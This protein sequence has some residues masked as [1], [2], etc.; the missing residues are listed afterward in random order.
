MG[1]EKTLGSRR[2]NED[3]SNSN[4]W[5]LGSALGED[6]G[7]RWARGLKV[8]KGE[9]ARGAKTRKPIKRKSS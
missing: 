8:G 1:W 7:S 3:N 9:K 4:C 2:M 5:S 6:Y